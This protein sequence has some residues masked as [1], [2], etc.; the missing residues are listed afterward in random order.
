MMCK[1]TRTFFMSLS[2][3]AVALCQT[4]KNRE[5]LSNSR[6]EIPG[7]VRPVSFTKAWS[8]AATADGVGRQPR[9]L[10]MAKITGD[11]GQ[12]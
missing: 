9:S 7:T 3:H 2:F 12:P 10:Q 5:S 4:S 11:R 8:V 1:G 6:R